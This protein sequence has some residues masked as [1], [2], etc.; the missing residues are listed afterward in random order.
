MNKINLHFI[1]NEKIEW[2]MIG[3][4]VKRKILGYD[5]HL[6]MVLV[7]FKKG[8]VGSIHKHPHRQATYIGKGKF[9]TII[10][11]HEKILK[12]GDSFFVT[13]DIDHGI[14]CLEEGILIDVFSPY[15]KDFLKK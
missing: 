1:E 3:K 6:M 5:K 11:N 10:D 14:I 12:E 15:K 13:P 4:G 8:A 9:K 2:E 7:H